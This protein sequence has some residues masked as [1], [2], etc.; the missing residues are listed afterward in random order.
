MSD[1]LKGTSEALYTSDL[2]FNGVNAVTGDYG[3]PPLSPRTLARLIRGEPFP[4]DYREF[5]DRQRLLSGL[6]TVE[7]RLTRVTD[8]QV[9]LRATEDKVRRD[10]LRRKAREWG[11]YPVKPGAGDPANVADVGWAAVFPAEMHPRLREEIKEAL[12]PLFDLR[13]TQAGEF[14]RLYEGGDAYRPGERKDQF[15]E[16]LGVG[17]GLVD[18]RE[19]PFYVL[20]VGTPAQIPYGFQYQLDVMRGVGRLDFGSDVDAYDR[21]A[22][23]VV[24]AEVN[25]SHGGTVPR[26]AAFFAPMNPGDKAT[27]LSAQYLVQPLYENLSQQTIGNDLA[28][29]VPWEVGTPIVGEKLA[30]RVRLEAL[31]GGDPAQTPALLFAA[32]HGLE[33]PAGHPAQLRQQGALLCQD[34]PGQGR[35]VAREHYFAGEDIADSA[36]LQGMIAFFFACYGAGTPELDQFAAQAFKVREKIAP[37]AFTAALPQQLLAHGALAVLGHVER[38]WGYSFIS[39]SGQL[40]HQSFITAMRTLMNGGP[41]GL[42]TDASFNMRYAEM[43]SDLSADLEELRWDPSH[44]DD[45]ELAHRWT[46]NN[47]ARSYVVLGDPAARFTL[48]QEAAEPKQREDVGTITRSEP[49]SEPPQVPEP[50][51][52]EP[53][54]PAPTEDSAKAGVGTVQFA[55]SQAAAGPSTPLRGQPMPRPWAGAALRPHGHERL[56]TEPATRVAVLDADAAVAFGLGDQFNRLRDSL[57]SFTDQLA[58][59]L[60]RAAQDIITL[61]VKTYSTKDIA[62]VAAALD[63]RNEVDANLRA[64]TRVAFDG[65]L[66][67]YVPETSA[68]DRQSGNV[69]LALW[70]IHRSMVEEAQHSR[71]RFL[72]TMAELATRLLDSL[73]IGS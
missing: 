71:A 52:Q 2:V 49:R 5:V 35:D 68:G 53:E 39:P 69:D 37:Q 4:Q 18:P 58:T 6:T 55:A 16:R 59:S 61:D 54:E 56:A 34:W 25:R 3:Q 23:A 7:E 21:Y 24:A 41:V 27:K 12:R 62:A 19:M 36:D 50:E 73:Q 17:P 28:L 38:A 20:L 15:L 47:D 43:S 70:E 8:A 46:A 48:V 32:C 22:R 11:V 31:L 57:R 40:E 10:E 67:V 26:R 13:R 72:A 66:Q 60:G 44:L 63:A 33:F 9:E 51:I 45:Y 14:F 1:A 65:D 64:L 29:S 42:A 30:T